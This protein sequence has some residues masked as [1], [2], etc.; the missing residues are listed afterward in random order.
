MF[1]ASLFNVK[2]RGLAKILVDNESS[3]ISVLT[4]LLGK[5]NSD[6]LPVSEDTAMQTEDRSY[7]AQCRHEDLLPN[8]TKIYLNLLGK[9]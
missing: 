4:T 2:T 5:E 6:S 1:A 7:S 3:D 8:R 9:I